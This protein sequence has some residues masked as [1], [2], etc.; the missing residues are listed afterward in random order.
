MF[1]EGK[2]FISEKWRAEVF[3]LHV[4][5]RLEEYVK[6]LFLIKCLTSEKSDTPTFVFDLS[7]F[8]IFEKHEFDDSEERQV[9][10]DMH[11]MRD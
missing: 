2:S 4:H 7:F 3:K 10:Q 5:K 1:V 8:V 6:M 9:T 11:K